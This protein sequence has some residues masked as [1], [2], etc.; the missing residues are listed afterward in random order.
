MI[1]QEFTCNIC[2]GGSKFFPVGDW[3]ESPTCTYCGSSVR[4]RSIMHCLTTSIYKKSLKL[5]DIEKSDLE[6]I[7]LSDWEGYSQI[8]EKKFNYFNTYYHKEPF[9]DI[10]SPPEKFKNAF[11]FLISTEVFEHIPPPVNTAFA[12]A[13]SV[14]KSKGL[15][16]LSVPYGS[17]EKT[18]EHFPTIKKF[19]I[20]DFFEKKILIN[21]VKED[22]YETFHKLNF[23]GGDGATLELRIFSLSD[24]LSNLKDNE[25]VNITIHKDEYPNFGIFH[26]HNM[27]LVI[28]AIKK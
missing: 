7:G 22:C 18:I 5:Q 6:G 16:V 8:L 15:L 17:Q 28:S 11:D 4:M 25:F 10:T 26:A 27:G 19:K 14:L 2:G 3:R 9:F 1:G 13:S 24:L 20:I 12:G 23:H 21:E